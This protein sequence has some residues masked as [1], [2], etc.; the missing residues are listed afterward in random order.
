[1]GIYTEFLPRPCA[2]ASGLGQ[3]G[4]LGMETIQ[5]NTNY[6]T[7]QHHL[8]PGL[9]LAIITNP[10]G[11][12]G[13][14]MFSWEVYATCRSLGIPAILATFDHNRTYPEI[15]LDLRRLAAPGANIPCGAN[16][17]KLE[18]FMDVAAEARSMHKFLV[19]DLN[20]GFS[21]SPEVLAALRTGGIREAS[22]IAALIAVQP[23]YANSWGSAIAVD[24][25]Q[26]I[27][28]HFDRGLFRY[29]DFTW[30]LTPPA[31]PKNPNFPVWTTSWLSQRAIALINYGLKRAGQPTIH[32]VP[33]LTPTLLRQ[34]LPAIDHGPLLQAI[35]HLDAARKTIYD[36]I[37]SPISKPVP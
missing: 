14:S 24:A 10:S 37:L 26:S 11:G 8:I 29:W 33:G 7:L 23:G 16:S 18:N 3:A 30:D 15:G 35:E 34:S 9:H 12:C 19:I 25:F 6:N 32:L 28:I 13:G 20:A 27:G 17:L 22:S 4:R 21:S 5:N 36:A 31:I 2:C 1:M